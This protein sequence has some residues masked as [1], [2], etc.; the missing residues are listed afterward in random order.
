MSYTNTVFVGTLVVM[1]G[2]AGISA[3]VVMVSINDGDAPSAWIW[4]ALFVVASLLAAWSFW[5]ST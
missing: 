5:R 1:A 4:T 2:I 3:W